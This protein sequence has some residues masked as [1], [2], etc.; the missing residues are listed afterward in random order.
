MSVSSLC[1]RG[2]CCQSKCQFHP[3]VSRVHTV[4]L[5]LWLLMCT[6]VT[7]MRSYFLDSKP[8]STT[9]LFSYH[10]F[11][12]CNAGD[13]GLIPGS[14]RSPGE[15]TGYILQYSWASLVVQLVKNLPA[16]QEE[17]ACSAGKLGSIPGLGRSLEKGKAT[18]SIFWLEISMDCILHGVPKVRHD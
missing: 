7:W 16:M 14:G 15:G 1:I 12:T 2:P 13:P 9:C 6:L 8:L 10:N 17:S 18:H 11:A 4:N 3:P 5:K